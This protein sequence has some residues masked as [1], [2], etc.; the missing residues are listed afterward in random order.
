[1]FLWAIVL[2]LSIVE[3]CSTQSIATGCSGTLNCRKVAMSDCVEELTG[4]VLN[5]NNICVDNMKKTC[6][7][8]QTEKECARA[9]CFW[10]NPPAATPSPP[11]D[12][13]NTFFNPAPAES[14]GSTGLIVGIVIA[15]VVLICLLGL[16][17]VFILKKQKTRIVEQVPIE[18][19]PAGGSD[20]VNRYDAYQQQPA[21][22]GGFAP[23]YN[24]PASSGWDPVPPSAPPASAP[25][26]YNPEWVE[27][28]H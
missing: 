7:D 5:S 20:L 11:F 8:F 10:Y 17:C 9:A 19:P 23:N 15:V 22:A 28:I 2:I 4:C 21:G 25:P 6:D 27:E 3:L 18:N 12:Q 26:P 1:M 16:V 14:G 13:G 24:V